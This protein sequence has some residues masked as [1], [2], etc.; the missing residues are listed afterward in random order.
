MLFETPKRFKKGIFVYSLSIFEL[1]MKN[2]KAKTKN[3]KNGIVDNSLISTKNIN[4][5]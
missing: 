1:K 3:A 5:V 2:C 4:K